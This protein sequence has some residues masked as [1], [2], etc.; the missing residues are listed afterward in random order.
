MLKVKLQICR[1]CL[2]QGIDKEENI[3]KF[4]DGEGDV[5]VEVSED[6][7]VFVNA[8]LVRRYYGGPEEGGWWYNHYDCLE[9][10]P[11][12]NKYSDLMV[13]ELEKQYG[14]KRFGDIYSSNGG[15]DVYVYIEEKPQEMQS[16]ERPQY[17]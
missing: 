12:K 6:E 5:E 7:I 8:Y 13:D 11:V 16:K 15:Q 14:H 2:G 10:V 17:E 9:A 4:C 1:D 3:C